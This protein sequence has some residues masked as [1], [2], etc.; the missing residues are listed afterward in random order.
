MFVGDPNCEI[1]GACL[2]TWVRS[3]AYGRVRGCG[4]GKGGGGAGAGVDV[5][6]GA[7]RTAPLGG[8]L[9]VTPPVHWKDVCYDIKPRVLPKWLDRMDGEVKPG[10]F[11]Y[12]FPIRFECQCVLIVS[13]LCVC[14]G[15]IRCGQD[16]VL[17]RPREPRDWV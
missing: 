14:V 5:E 15:R 12:C 2:S 10:A 4:D 3:G 7:V 9:G 1:E 17:G 11:R 8:T 13:M 6:K 16:D